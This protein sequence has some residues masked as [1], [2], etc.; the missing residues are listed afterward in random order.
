[1]IVMKKIIFMLTF[2][3]SVLV[4]NGQVDTTYKKMHSKQTTIKVA[5]L[6]KA[7]TDNVA[8]MYP[9]YT[10]QEASTAMENNALAYFV[11][12]S[13]GSATETLVYDKEG[14]FLKKLEKKDD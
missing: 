8:K 4:V 7:I 6:P 13:N 10:V 3:M 9:G 14:K 2:L 12:V 1:M 11:V 5:D